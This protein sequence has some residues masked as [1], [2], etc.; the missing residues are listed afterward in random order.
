MLAY[1][2]FLIAPSGNEMLC[3]F[4]GDDEVR[5]AESAREIEEKLPNLA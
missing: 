1:H 4:F 3:I 2:V 5:P